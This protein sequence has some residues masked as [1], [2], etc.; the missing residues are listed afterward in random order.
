MHVIA[1]SYARGVFDEKNRE[2]MRMDQ[3]AARLDS[4]TLIVFSRSVHGRLREFEKGNLRVI[5]TNSH[6]KLQ[7]LL[8]AYRI[9]KMVLSKRK[10]HGDYVITSQ[11]PFESG[12]VGALLA[13]A[14]CVRHH[15][16]VHGSFFS[17]DAWKRESVINR[18]RWFLGVYLLRHTSGIRVV[19]ERIKQ[20][21]LE[22]RI[23]ETRITVLPIRPE[24]E[25]IL[26]QKRIT[27]ES[28]DP[29]TVLYVGRL[30]R[31]K[32]IPLI[33]ESVARL[34]VEFP[35]LSLRIVGSGIEH[36]RLALRINAL[37]AGAFVSLIPWTHD[38]AH[39][40]VHADI[41]ALASNHEGYALVL[42]EAMAAGLPVVTTD[43]GC[44]GEVLRDGTEGM[45]VP[46][47]DLKAFTGALRTLLQ[48][49]S[50]RATL[51]MA[52]RLR[53]V[54]FGTLAPD[55][56]ADQWVAALREAKEQV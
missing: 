6:T 25:H 52:G 13:R 12:L 16:Q 24:I 17:G 34:K 50:L 27:R 2:R 36:E 31:E 42:L 40:M 33:I 39:E 32:N 30:A 56:Y 22:L 53:A 1:L 26:K 5:A 44:V 18:V 51:G 45:V 11:D 28:D 49:S 14:L 23:P 54:Q 47:G 21:L 55:A 37:H 19:S 35:T 7:V 38:V 20:S 10:A 8:D 4:L 48:D 29:L 3:Y 46:I 41:F 9:G 43:V 15:I